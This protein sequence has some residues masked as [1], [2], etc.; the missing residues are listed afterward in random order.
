MPDGSGVA[1]AA[2]QCGNG[3]KIE[4]PTMRP[5]NKQARL[6]QGLR[7]YGREDLNLQPPEASQGK[8]PYWS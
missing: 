1:H 7:Q 3:I 6:L 2:M 5:Q 8:L 4:K